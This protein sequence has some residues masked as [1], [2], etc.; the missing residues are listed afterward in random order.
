VTGY[1][2]QPPPRTGRYNQAMAP[3]AHRLFFAIIP[4]AEA[5][6]SISRV[7]LEVRE[8][9]TI[10]GSWIEPERYHL[11][12]QFLGDFQ[13][14]DAI[15]ATAIAAAQ[16]LRFAPV[17]FLLDRVATFGGRFRAPCVLRCS[18]ESD[19]H[20]LALWRLQGDALKAAGFDGDTQRRFKPHVTIAYGDQALAEPMAIEPIAWRAEEF[21]LVDSATGR[22]RHDV[23]GRWPLT[24]P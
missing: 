20:A 12:L 24:G 8:A 13:E 2:R 4:G 9:R 19:A 18:R 14:P 5:L 6:R 3:A 7:A 23:I 21:V 16:Q 15:I 1:S 17:D 22:G 11:T 10:R